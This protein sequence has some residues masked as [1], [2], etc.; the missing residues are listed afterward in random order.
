MKKV[1][2]IILLG[3]LAVNLSDCNMQLVN[4]LGIVQTV[5]RMLGIAYLILYIISNYIL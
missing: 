3:F 2:A 5:A 1:V 4:V